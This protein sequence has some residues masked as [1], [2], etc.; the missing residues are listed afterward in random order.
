VSPARVFSINTSGGGVPKLPVSEAEVGELGIAGDDHDD[1]KN[2]GGPRQ[3]LCLYSVDALKRL[4]AEGHPVGP[5]GMGEN[6]TFEGVDV[7]D[8]HPGDQLRI[9]AIEVEITGYAGP[10]KTIAGNFKDGVFTRVSEKA[11]IE[12]CR[13]YARIIRGGRIHQG[14]PVELMK[15]ASNA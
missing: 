9:G 3:A 4:Q 14:D 10:C 12:D 6:I 5:G 2:H 11:H 1:K 15:E 7:S 8:L 13:L